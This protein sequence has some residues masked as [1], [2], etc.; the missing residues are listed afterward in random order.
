MSEQPRMKL[1]LHCG[2][3]FE[4]ANHRIGFCSEECRVLK[5]A[6]QKREAERL[7]RK[8]NTA[9]MRRVQPKKKKSVPLTGLTVVEVNILARKEG[10]SYG[11]MVPKLEKA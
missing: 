8:L 6:A 2:R 4:A 5:H 9:A 7:N 3:S 1:C 11:K 10:T